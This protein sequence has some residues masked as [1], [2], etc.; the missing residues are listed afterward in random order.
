M[1]ETRM[2]LR[3]YIKHLRRARAAIEKKQDE[4][5]GPAVPIP[6]TMTPEDSEFITLG[7]VIGDLEKLAYDPSAS[8]WDA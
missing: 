8:Y 1:D 3:D 6:M 7:V 2:K 5:M 4:R